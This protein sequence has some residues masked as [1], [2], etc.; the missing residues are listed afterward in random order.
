M[1][2]LVT[3]VGSAFTSATDTVSPLTGTST[4]CSVVPNDPDEEVLPVD[5]L[6]PAS[7]KKS[8][9]EG[10]GTEKILNLLTTGNECSQ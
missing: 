10:R 1:G 4:L 9:M 2:V 8:R 5:Q 6:P 7:S 3:S